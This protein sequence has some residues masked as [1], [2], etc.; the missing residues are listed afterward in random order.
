MHINEIAA[1]LWEDFSSPAQPQYCPYSAQFQKWVDKLL[2]SIKPALK[3]DSVSAAIAIN[4]AKVLLIDKYFE[5]L[6]ATPKSHHNRTGGDHLCLSNVFHN[7]YLVIKTGELMVSP[8]LLFLPPP[9]PARM[10][11]NLSIADVVAFGPVGLD[12]PELE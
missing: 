3:K 1:N 5:W 12:L 11:R 6:A 7:S 2:A 4:Q 8:P 9:P 10:P